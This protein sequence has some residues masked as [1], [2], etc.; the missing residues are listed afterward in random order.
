[1]KRISDQITA[2]MQAL[3]PHM[4]AD[5]IQRKVSET[6]KGI[7][8]VA[9]GVFFIL[10]GFGLAIT[11][12]LITKAT[13]SLPLVGL[14]ALPAIPGAYFLLAGGNLI[15]R[16]AMR[17]AEVSGDIITRTAAK[18]L[19]RGRKVTPIPDGDS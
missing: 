19:N 8:F 3:N 18:V 10:L 11:I 6:R 7:V 13:V 5:R 14:C 16:D 1:M 2:S 4:P 17:A 15:S 12:L 9:L